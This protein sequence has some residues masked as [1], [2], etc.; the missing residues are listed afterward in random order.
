MS[1]FECSSRPSTTA[2]ILAPDIV[3]YRK[4]IFESHREA[5][6]LSSTRL[7]FC[8]EQTT[9]RANSPRL[10]PSFKWPNH[11]R[12]ANAYKSRV[13]IYDWLLL[14]DATVAASSALIANSSTSSWFVALFC[15]KGF[16]HK[17]NGLDEFQLQVAP[18]TNDRMA[19]FLEMASASTNKLKQKDVKIF[20]FLEK[21]P[22]YNNN[23]KKTRFDIHQFRGR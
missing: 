6:L 8:E 13:K 23:N 1:R 22:F 7:H 3:N 20:E 5:N 19:R 2:A 21:T 9:R 12:R 4:S 10:R 14:R 15:D 17:F 18:P 11:L 16:E